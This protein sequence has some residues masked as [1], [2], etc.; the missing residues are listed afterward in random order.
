MNFR[1]ILL[2]SL[3]CVP[4]F[5]QT[6]GEQKL[7]MWVPLSGVM[8]GAGSEGFSENHK[9]EASSNQVTTQG[10]KVPPP[11]QSLKSGGLN[12]NQAVGYQW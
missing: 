4:V 9:N 5:G 12:F 7:L 10:L 3:I 6:S 8:F 1:T 11:S 2:G